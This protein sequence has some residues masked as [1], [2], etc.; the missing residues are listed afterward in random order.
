MPAMAKIF[1]TLF[2]AVFVTTMGA[3]LVAPLLPVYA[4]ELGAS[5][6]QI[7]FIFAAFSITRSLFVPYFGK[8]SD[9]RGR[10]PFLSLG[11]LIYFLLSLLYALSHDVM[12]LIGLRLA[13]GFA[14]A[15]ILPVALAYVGDITPPD[16]EGR[17]MGAFNISIYF[18]LSVGPL[19]GGILRD[20]FDIRVSFLSMGGLTLVGFLLCFFL[21][22]AEKE[23]RNPRFSKNVKR[24]NYMGIMK[25][26]P[27]M[28]LF[29]FRSC[30]TTCIGITWAFI[31]LLGSSELKLSSSLIGV[32]VAVNVLVAGLLQTPMGYVADNY[33]KKILVIL[34]GIVAVSA[35]LYLA[36]APSFFHLALANTLFGVAGG[37]SLPAIMALAV[38]EGRR[39]KAMGSVMGLLAQAHSLGMLIGPLIGGILLDTTSFAIIFLMGTFI[40]A[41][42]TLLFWVRYTWR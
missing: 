24:A 25:N 41:V 11:L 5:A 20:W 18:G 27:I 7:G 37:V 36:F 33:N 3:G 9:Q 19:L 16:K 29:I 34:G 42:G 26:P 32:V 2:L 13:Q 23:R 39:V 31:P 17:M 30:F 38:I 35:T 14:S 15:M 6:L 10:K 28:A 4:N 12:A 8:L 22:P 40:I 1:A 21:L